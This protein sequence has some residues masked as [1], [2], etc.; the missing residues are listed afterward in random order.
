[1]TTETAVVPDAGDYALA[2]A[3]AEGLEHRCYTQV[4]GDHVR[5]FSP[6]VAVLTEFADAMKKELE[7]LPDHAVERISIG[8]VEAKLQERSKRVAAIWPEVYPVTMRRLFQPCSDAQMSR[9]Q[10]ELDHVEFERVWTRAM[11]LV[12]DDRE[13]AE[14]LIP[15]D[16]MGELQTIANGR[17]ARIQAMYYTWARMRRRWDRLVRHL[18][19]QK[20]LE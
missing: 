4:D 5:G 2:E 12:G 15:F 19:R 14:R 18:M 7:Q 3:I 13:I 16:S 9:V 1:M 10:Y 20:D 6:R 8:D 17:T 11:Q